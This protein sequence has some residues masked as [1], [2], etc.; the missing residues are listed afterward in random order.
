MFPWYREISPIERRTFW[1]CF[2]G[3]GLD[4]LD[5][6]MVSIALPALIVAFG[7]DNADA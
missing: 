4:A 5:V 7:L 3:W 1:S 2:G 6:Q